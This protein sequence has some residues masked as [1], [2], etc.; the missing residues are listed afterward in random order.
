MMLRKTVR[1]NTPLPL[2]PSSRRL[3]R[4]AAAAAGI[5]MT[6]TVATAA[7]VAFV[8]AVL[9]IA[10]PPDVR[11]NQ[12]QSDTRIFAFNE[13]QCFPL[14]A[15]VYTD[16]GSISAG[17]W[18][19]C[20]LLHSDPV[21]PP[22][23]LSGAVRFSAPILGVISSSAL[24]DASDGVCGWPVTTYPA[25]GAEAFRGLEPLQPNDQYA[26][27][28][29]TDLQVRMDVPAYSDQIRVITECQ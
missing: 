29:P 26:V 2:S 5:A 15:K 19:S 1:E 4:V 14:P 25:P 3:L 12:L 23:L 22:I 10:P 18:V 21:N 13:R 16:E 27:V 8:P 7:I 6:G 24:L 20:H 28:A 9:Q 11:L 17:T